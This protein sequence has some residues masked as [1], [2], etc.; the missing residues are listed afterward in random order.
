MATVTARG[1]FERIW[2]HQ[3]KHGYRISKTPPR[4][5]GIYVAVGLDLKEGDVN[6]AYS[7]Y[8]VQILLN[9]QRH[10]SGTILALVAGSL[11]RSQ[12][13]KNMSK[14]SP[15]NYFEHGNPRLP[16]YPRPA[17]SHPFPQTRPPVATMVRPLALQTF[18]WRPLACAKF[19]QD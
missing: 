10:L 1:M 5:C 16:R 15:A 9:C 8:Q 12:K 2:K 3:Q 7:P 18:R 6:L 17:W 11:T 4:L 14:S 13:V 19:A